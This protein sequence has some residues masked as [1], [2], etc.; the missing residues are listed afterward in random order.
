[1]MYPSL[2][3]V[4]QR[5]NIKLKFKEINTII[6]TFEEYILSNCHE[7]LNDLWIF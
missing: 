1:M 2:L 4:L 3:L 7:T 6:L 5:N